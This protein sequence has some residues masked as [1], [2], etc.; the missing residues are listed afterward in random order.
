MPK[1]TNMDKHLLDYQDN[2]IPHAIENAKS[3]G[4]KNFQNK[5]SIMQDRYQAG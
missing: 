1:V 4:K 2:R 5:E 3:W